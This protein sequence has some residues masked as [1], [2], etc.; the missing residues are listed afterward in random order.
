MTAR[1][2]ASLPAP[3]SSVQVAISP[4]ELID[5]IT[6]LEIKADRI[7]A[8]DKRANVRHEL[9]ALRATRAA[10]IPDSDAL[11]RLAID[12]RAV[13][14][15]LWDVEDELRA[16]ERQSR[17]DDRFVA[18]ARAVYRNNDR[19]AALKA[20]INA[21]LGSAITEEKSYAAY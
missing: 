4:G 9:D 12:L 7:A 6:I 17:F 8:P 16:C 5:R 13:N 3:V 19:R 15:R 18:L 20:E 10:S 2:V 14:T 11:D 21:L 1:N